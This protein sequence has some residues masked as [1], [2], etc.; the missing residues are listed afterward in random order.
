MPP[1][2]R[3]CSRRPWRE[4]SSRDEI[5]RAGEGRGRQLSVSAAPLYGRE[6][7]PR[8]VVLAVED[9]SERR[10]LEEQLRQAQKMEAVGQLTGGFAHDF[11]NLLAVI[12]GNLDMAAEAAR[13]GAIKEPIG[14]AL[15]AAQRGAELT[16]AAAR[17]LA[18]AALA[19]PRRRGRRPRSRACAAS[20]SARW[21]SG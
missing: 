12:I 13:D 9:V 2:L 11:N 16:R 10:L 21:A 15:G 6:G 19:A 5:L 14:E 20:C 18:P 3:R 17:L 7:E 4:S 8:G 1:A